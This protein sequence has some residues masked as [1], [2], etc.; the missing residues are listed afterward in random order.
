[1]RG[2]RCYRA[3]MAQYDY[4]P[5]LSVDAPVHVRAL[6]RLAPET[7]AVFPEGVMINWL[8]R[9]PNPT[10]YVNFMPPELILFGEDAWLAAFRAN[11][12]DVVL[13]VHKDTSEYGAQFFGRDYA[14]ELAAWIGQTYQPQKLLGDE[15]L[16]P[17]SRWGIRVLVRRRAP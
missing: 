7:L 6:E 8:T 11:P 10:P 9:V 13:I 1:M 3:V 16:L 14:R 4:D 17:D 15:P 2:S 5:D 12:P